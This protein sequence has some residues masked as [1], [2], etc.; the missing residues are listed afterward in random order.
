M[1]MDYPL[2]YMDKTDA[3]REGEAVITRKIDLYEY[4]KVER[5]PGA[6]GK[7]TCWAGTTSEKVSPCR[8]RPAVLILP[9]GAYRWT[10]PREAEPV[11]LQFAARGYAAFVLDYTCAP[12]GFPVPLRE[13]AMAMRY[14]REN[15]DLFEVDPHMVAAMGFSAG[16]HL[17]GTLGMMYDCQE[18]QDLGSPAQIRPDALALC[19]PV[20]VS[21]GRTHEESFENIS[22]G[23]PGLRARLSLERLVRPDMPP[24]FLWHTRDDPSVPCRNSLVLATALEEAEV[25]FAMHI[26]R[27]GR[28]G[29]STADEMVYPVHGVPE[30]SWD[31][32]GW[33][34]AEIRFFREIGF[35]ITDKEEKT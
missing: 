17:C 2:S 30:A 7:L 31:V 22:R 15:A 19:Y 9:G 12:E 34:D 28:H 11:A 6:V 3:K 13:A 26:Y 29:L 8:R 32:P 35:K 25:S 10:S 18:L 33:L 21:W 20:A 14:I 1:Q 24:V 16:G 23:D 5:R 27:H 4:W